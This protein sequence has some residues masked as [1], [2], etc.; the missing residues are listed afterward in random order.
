MHL[1]PLLTALRH[2]VPFS[3]MSAILKLSEFPVSQGADRTVE[4]IIKEVGEGK[5]DYTS[6]IKKLKQQ[7]HD[8]LLVSEKAI[9]FF[10]VDKVRIAKLTN[11]ITKNEIKNSDFLALY[12][13]PLS[14]E[15]LSKTKSKISLVDLVESEQS[16][17]LVY[18]S[19]RFIQERVKI[20]TSELNPEVEKELSSY[21]E[22]YGIKKYFYQF[23]DTVVLWKNKPF[24]EVRV[25]VT[26]D[27]PWQDRRKYALEVVGEFNNLTN[28]VLGIES[29]LRDSVNFFPLI[30]K[31]YD[32]KDEGK[33]GELAF[34]TDEGSIK[35][36][37]MRVGMV[38]LR[39][40]TYHKAG[41]AAVD[42]ICPYRIAVLWESPISETLSIKNNLE[43]FLQGTCKS[44]SSKN[45]V[46][47]DVIIKKCSFL[48]E[49]KF[50]FDKINK[51]LWNNNV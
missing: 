24:V 27:M 45:Q 42:D 20:D 4:R 6:A 11:L 7:Y 38:D 34:T 44:L 26:R 46:L 18:C 3:T 12:P 29:L 16:L 41:R 31:L 23:F 40:E 19:S 9:R 35:N 13:I 33:V 15:Q 2:R 43:L 25:D 48:E 21:Y 49:Y 28:K 8:H 39:N 5:E 1:E 32:A 51:Y 17:S 10:P 37:K 47:E 14:E 50:V 36:E 30:K 22:V